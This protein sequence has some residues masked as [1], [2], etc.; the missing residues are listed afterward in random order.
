MMTIYEAG[1]SVNK[2][3]TDTSAQSN[4][5]AFIQELSTGLKSPSG[6]GPRFALIHAGGEHGFV[7]GAECTFLCN[8]NT[9]DV[10]SKM[11]ADTYGDWF[12]NKLLPNIPDVSRQHL[13]C[14]FC[15]GWSIRLNGP[16]RRSVDPVFS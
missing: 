2:K 8:K 13:E 9:A 6:L 14:V 10:H 1:H 16:K 15:I 7:V 5:Q 4:R 11:D 3:W 12:K